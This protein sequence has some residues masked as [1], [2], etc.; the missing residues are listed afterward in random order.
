MKSVFLLQHSYEIEEFDETKTIGIYSSKE[1]AEEAILRYKE[2]PGFRDYPVKCFYI[3]KY[4]LDLDHW[5]EGFIKWD[6]D[7]EVG[8]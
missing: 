5:Q 4:E 2:L 7:N 1:K 3:D 8:E 6:E